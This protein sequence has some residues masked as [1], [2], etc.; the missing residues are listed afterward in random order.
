MKNSDFNYFKE[1]DLDPILGAK[2]ATTLQNVMEIHPKRSIKV[3]EVSENFGFPPVIVKK[4]IYILFAQRKI[5]ATY[6]A[7]HKACD[8]V[9]S[10]QEQSPQNIIDK[11]FDGTINWCTKCNEPIESIDDIII[12]MVFWNPSV[13]DK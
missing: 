7:R 4:V 8:V 2:I 12:E 9:L 5:K 1:L 3:Q 10:K 13:D 6:I 11:I